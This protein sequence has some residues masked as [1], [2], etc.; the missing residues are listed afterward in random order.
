MIHC[1]CAT[2]RLN[3]YQGRSYI[4]YSGQNYCTAHPQY[5]S[6]KRY[7]QAL[8]LLGAPKPDTDW[9][10]KVH[11]PVVQTPKPK[12]KPVLHTYVLSFR[13]ARGVE[14]DWF[15]KSDCD[16]DACNQAQAF[17]KCLPF[18]NSPFTLIRETEVRLLQVLNR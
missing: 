5:I 14:Q 18:C 7:K 12:P 13:D 8:D 16:E 9:Y 1:N 2:C 15:I 3:G 6:I 4:E 10:S 11:V 17:M